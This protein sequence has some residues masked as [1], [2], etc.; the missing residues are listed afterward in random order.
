MAEGSAAPLKVSV[1]ICH[2]YLNLHVC[3][4]V[5]WIVTK[6]YFGPFGLL[7]LFRNCLY[8]VAHCAVSLSTFEISS[9]SHPPPPLPCYMLSFTS[10]PPPFP[11]IC[12]LFSFFGIL[13]MLYPGKRE[14]Y[15][16]L[17]TLSTVL[18]GWG[19]H[20]YLLQKQRNLRRV[21]L[22]F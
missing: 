2:Q 17:L 4:H 20:I 12:F 16:L 6:L 5:C 14:E 9:L 19:T 1:L 13:I 10:P 7:N 8:G 22:N 3:H 18:M 21:L 15:H 11:V